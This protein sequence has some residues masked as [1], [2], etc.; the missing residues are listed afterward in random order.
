MVNALAVGWR[1]YWFP[2]GGQKSA[3][4]VRISVA[5][6][7]L[8]SLARLQGNPLLLHAA[9]A[10]R[11][12]SHP[13]GVLLLLGSTP[14]SPTLL[15]L[16]HG[17]ALVATLALL[18]GWRTRTAAALALVSML[19]VASFSVSFTPD[20][21]HDLNLPLLALL[22]LQGT[23]AG[24]VLGVDGWWR[25]RRGLLAPL[26]DGFAWT[27][28]LVQLVAALMF[29]AAAACKLG[30]GHFTLRPRARGQ[31]QCRSR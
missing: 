13:V 16:A 11:A 12:P 10:P 7:V 31:H 29:L 3:A 22:A 6:T 25:R 19:L 26:A 15:A 14:P 20:W 2:A 24:D 30:A 18:V 17:L 23:Q 8:A 5:L 27:Q 1:R 28:R 9:A 4:A 21:P